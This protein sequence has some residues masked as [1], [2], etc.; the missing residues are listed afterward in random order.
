[1]DVRTC[2][3]CRRIF[4]Y[5]SG[6]MLC[7]ACRQALEEKFQEVKKYIEEHGRATLPQI[8]EACDVDVQQI[9][10]WLREERLELASDAGF[11][12]ECESCGTPIRSGRFCDKC[13]TSMANNM[14]SLINNSKPAQPTLYKKDSNARMRLRQD[15]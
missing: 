15:D 3:G 13:R 5:V 1:M 10:Q 7:P 12:L 11:V 4:N 2:R 14:Q 6:P 9:R 8:A